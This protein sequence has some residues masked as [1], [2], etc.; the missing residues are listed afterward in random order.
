MVSV[1][2]G[3]ID[4]ADQYMSKREEEHQPVFI[5]RQT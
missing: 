5:A 3:Y 1:D 2:R 4:R